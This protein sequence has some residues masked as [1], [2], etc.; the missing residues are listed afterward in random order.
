MSP[1]SKDNTIFST[2]LLCTTSE[3]RVNVTFHISPLTES[4]QGELVHAI[5]MDGYSVGKLLEKVLEIN[6][7]TNER[8]VYDFQTASWNS[9]PQIQLSQIEKIYFGCP[10]M[11]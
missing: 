1:R 4:K 5:I 6:V 11:E 9:Y 2:D 3:G 8:R 10:H 7:L